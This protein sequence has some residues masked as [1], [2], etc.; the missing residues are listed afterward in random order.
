VERRLLRA[1]LVDDHSV[2]R[3]GLRFI[4]DG[5]DGIEVVGEAGAADEALEQ[6]R[7]VK[8]D[9]VFMDISL[10]GASGIELTRRVRRDYPE[11]KVIILTLHEDEHYFL[12]ALQAGASAYVVKG[13]RPEEL[14]AAVHAVRDDGTYLHPRLATGLVTRYLEERS[15]NAFD[16]LSPREREV[17]ELIIDGFSNQ[18][19]ALR[20]D[21][22][23]TTVQTHRSHIMEKLQLNN[24]GELIRYAIRHGVIEP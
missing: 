16:G 20:L 8:P 17:A 18:Q 5:V 2:V 14:V 1:V 11:T 15:N 24:Y 23:V 6:I 22:G 12:Q 9:V 3:A 21:I 19:I 10:P 13:S 7:T 4:L